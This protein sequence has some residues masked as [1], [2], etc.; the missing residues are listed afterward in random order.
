[1]KGQGTWN[2]E[3]W[4]GGEG[5]KKRR[6]GGGE[7]ARFKSLSAAPIMCA[8]AKSNERSKRFS[9]L[10]KHRASPARIE[11]W[12]PVSSRKTSRLIRSGR[13]S[14]ARASAYLQLNFSLVYDSSIIRTFPLLRHGAHNNL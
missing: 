8:G 4:Q 9:A 13:F 11:T 14:H 3:L 1:M 5:R 6:L 7:G 2:H 12:V 10:Q